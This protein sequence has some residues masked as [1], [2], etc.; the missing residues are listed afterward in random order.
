MGVEWSGRYGEG[1]EGHAMTRTSL[2]RAR[3]AMCMLMVI[4]PVRPGRP[5]L[6]LS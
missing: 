2:H 5:E 3:S 6:E 1:T 4:R